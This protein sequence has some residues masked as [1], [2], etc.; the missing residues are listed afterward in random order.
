LIAYSLPLTLGS[1]QSQ[2]GDVV[3]EGA[4]LGTGLLLTV[5]IAKMVAMALSLAVG[6]M[7]GNVFAVTSDAG[8]SASR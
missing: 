2:L 4:A 8:S 1:G 6:F 5:L 7:G 3:D